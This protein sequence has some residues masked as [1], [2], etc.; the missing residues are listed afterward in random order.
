[1]KGATNL[2]TSTHS[3]IHSH[4]HTHTPTHSVSRSLT[5]SLC[6]SLTHTHTHHDYLLS[7]EDEELLWVCDEE[8]CVELL[9]QHSAEEGHVLQQ[10]RVISTA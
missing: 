8:A 7:D 6:L 4:T 1:M 5:H 2:A 3:L 9:H 10:N